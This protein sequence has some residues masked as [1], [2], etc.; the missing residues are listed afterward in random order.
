MRRSTSVEKTLPLHTAEKPR[1]R[2][3]MKGALMWLALVTL[4]YVWSTHRLNRTFFKPG[5]ADIVPGQIQ[6]GR[7]GTTPFEST[8]F[9]SG[10]S[11]SVERRPRGFVSSR[12][13]RHT[14]E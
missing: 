14:H 12:N 10:S 6:Y 9:D 1:S 3:P 13:E 4:L 11:T 7:R 5:V 2:D 8:R